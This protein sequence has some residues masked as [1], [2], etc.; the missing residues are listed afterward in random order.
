MYCLRFEVYSKACC[1]AL[2]FE[3]RL[4]EGP[5][6]KNHRVTTPKVY[7]LKAR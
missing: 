3:A 5:G 7:G 6:Q 2:R 4:Q 1:L